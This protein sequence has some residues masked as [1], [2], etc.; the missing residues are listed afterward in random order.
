M[1]DILVEQAVFHTME[2][3]SLQLRARSPEFLDD[4]IAPC[5]KLCR[6]FGRPP[7]GSACPPALFAH[8]LNR[9]FVAVM[10]V[11]SAANEQPGP[12]RFHVSVLRADEYAGLGGD[13]FSVA[14]RCPPNLDASGELPTITWPR[15]AFPA[16]TVAQVRGVLQRA[17]GPNLLGGSQ[18]LLDGGRL[19]FERTE[20]DA[21]VLRDLWTL[22]PTRS[23][24]EMW[25]GTFAFSNSLRFHAIVAPPG[26]R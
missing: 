2:N 4:W 18:V 6:G 25:R 11:A 14:E 16:R 22:L 20:P 24:A 13:P 26:L 5:E 8:L 3:D 7:E 21:K 1:S 10:Q 23:R 19:A 12:L 15:V 17:D 9:H